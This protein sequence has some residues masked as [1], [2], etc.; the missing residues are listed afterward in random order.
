LTRRRKTGC[1]RKI[2]K[3][4]KVRTQ[5]EAITNPALE[6][7]FENLDYETDL[8]VPDQTLTIREILNRFTLGQPVEGGKSIDYDGTDDFDATD[9]TLDPDFDISDAERIIKDIKRNQAER[10]DQEKA[11][12]DDPKDPT[13][14]DPGALNAEKN[15]DDL[16]DDDK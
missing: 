14:I 4:M 13:K 12:R 2:K 15:D 3:T 1:R 11:I 16:N 9:P 8:T 5:I 10:N 6:G 7:R